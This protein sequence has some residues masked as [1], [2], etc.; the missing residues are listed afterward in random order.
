M[1]GGKTSE[2]SVLFTDIKDF[3]AFS[4]TLT[5][6]ELAAVLGRYLQVM[7]EIIQ[8]EKG[9]I[10]KYIGDAVMTFWNAPE[11]VA[12]HEILACRAA[13]RL[14]RCVARSCMTLPIG[15][16][17]HGLKRASASTAAWHRLAISAPQIG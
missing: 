5:P 11:P 13:L 2:L 12:G 7:A 3:T 8:S 14:P 16:V 17:L 9:T 4:E 10:D 1:L 6:D 15:G